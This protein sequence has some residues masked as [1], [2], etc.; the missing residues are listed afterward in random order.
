MGFE[1]PPENTGR[2]HENEGSA[3]RF[4]NGLVAELW[5]KDGP[6]WESV[7]DMR[8]RWG[9]EAR[10]QLVAGDSPR[11]GDRVLPESAPGSP[12]EE[13]ADFLG[14]WMQDLGLIKDKNIP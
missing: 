13:F 14:R 1:Q 8:T 9:I 2:E 5:T 3:R 7:R 10:P 4:K 11:V 12:W 6:F